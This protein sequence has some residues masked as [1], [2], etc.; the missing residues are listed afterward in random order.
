MK[1]YEFQGAKLSEIC[2]KNGWYLSQILL[3]TLPHVIPS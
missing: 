1:M 2:T 3:P